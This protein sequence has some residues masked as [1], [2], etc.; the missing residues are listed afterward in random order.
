MY[1]WTGGAAVIVLSECA[2]V[3]GWCHTFYGWS[4]GGRLRCGRT[5]RMRANESPD[6]THPRYGRQLICYAA[7]LRPALQACRR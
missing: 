6:L 5:G 4:L 3:L 2:G 1:G 7:A